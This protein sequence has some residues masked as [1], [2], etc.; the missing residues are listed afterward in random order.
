MRYIAEGPPHVLT[1]IGS[2]DG[3]T[4][5]TLTGKCEG[6]GMGTLTFDFSSKG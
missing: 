3:T 5:W 4:W 1:M 6:E 2:D